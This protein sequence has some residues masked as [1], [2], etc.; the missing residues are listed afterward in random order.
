MK[1]SVFIIA[2]CWIVMTSCAQQTKMSE[3]STGNDK[4]KT[5]S[6]AKTDKPGWKVLLNGKQV[7][8]TSTEN[9]SS[10]RKTISTAE[11]G[12]KAS[13]DIIYTESPDAKLK[14]SFIVMNN[15]RNE[16]LRKD[17]TTKFTLNSS[18][19][20]ALAQKSKELVIYT[21]GIPSDPAVAATVRVR[22][23][24]VFTLTVQ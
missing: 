24:H 8:Q 3:A 11:L 20:S 7:L 4:G 17:N 22:P 10:N 21:I 5:D 16:L 15:Q 1:Q 12:G 9:E 18:E 13:L 6:V 23:V 2:L 14:R 19:L